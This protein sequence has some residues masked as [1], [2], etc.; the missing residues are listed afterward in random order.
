M[1]LNIPTHKERHFH[2]APL[3]STLI[4]AGPAGSLMTATHE[5]VWCVLLCGRLRWPDPSMS[6]H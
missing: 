4:P 6:Y 3:R 2:P 1:P 5:G